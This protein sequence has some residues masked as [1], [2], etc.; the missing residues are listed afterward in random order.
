[1]KSSGRWV[2]IHHVIFATSEVFFSIILT[3]VSLPSFAWFMLLHCGDGAP[4][5]QPLHRHW[6]SNPWRRGNGVSLQFTVRP[7]KG[8][9]CVFVSVSGGLWLILQSQTSP[10]NLHQKFSPIELPRT[11]KCSQ[12]HLFFLKCQ[13]T[14][15]I[16]FVSPL[17]CCPEK[18]LNPT[19]VLNNP[20]AV[21]DVAT[22]VAHHTFPM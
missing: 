2:F 6:A 8:Y 1:M 5:V 13:R 10:V 9:D 16:N 12:I 19:H 22:S 4:A 17:C 11:V 14:D 15:L 18:R 3:R 21:L 7:L 20:I